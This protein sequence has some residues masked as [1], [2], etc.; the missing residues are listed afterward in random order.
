MTTTISQTGEMTTHLTDTR[1]WF[2]VKEENLYH[3]WVRADLGELMFSNC[4]TMDTQES[5]RNSLVQKESI[6]RVSFDG[7]GVGSTIHQS[8]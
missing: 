5:A 2:K 1:R 6:V 7:R 4:R 3:C 8:A